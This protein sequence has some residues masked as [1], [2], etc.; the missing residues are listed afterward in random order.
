[1]L[2]LGGQVLG[3]ELVLEG[4]AVGLEVLVAGVVELDLAG[5]DINYII[6][7]S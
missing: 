7:L 5:F 6:E 2:G 4:L 3:G 1:M